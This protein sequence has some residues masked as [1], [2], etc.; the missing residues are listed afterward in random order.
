MSENPRPDIEPSPGTLG[1]NQVNV[2][3]SSNQPH[4]GSCQFLWKLKNGLTKKLPKRSKQT[5][6]RTTAVHDVE[7]EG[8]SSSQQVESFG[9][10]RGAQDTLHLHPSNDNKHP[11]TSEIPSDSVNQGLSG[12]SASQVQAASSGK[13][14]RPDPHLVDVE[15][16][17]ACDGTQNM[18]SLG[19][20]ATSTASA[21]DNA[22][23]DLTAADGFEKTYLQ[24]L[25]IIDA[26]LEKISDV[27]AIPVDW[28]RTNQVV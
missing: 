5:R 7:N 18:R 21:V 3:E 11:T 26:V 10:L 1:S 19:K 16:Q 24:P 28:N 9:F 14:G 12:E 8:T 4:R 13:P 6:N 23:A 22:P 15:L 20:H 2:T 27:W 25:K 17:G